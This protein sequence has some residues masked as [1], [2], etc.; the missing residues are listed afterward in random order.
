M[1]T[2]PT[3]RTH[4]RA[5]SLSAV[6]AAPFAALALGLALSGALPARAQTVTETVAMRD[7]TGLATDVYLPAATPPFP[8]L[9]YRTPYDKAGMRDQANAV[10]AA[11]DVAV[12]VQDTRG[13]FASAGVDCIFRCELGDG[14]GD[15]ED[16]L[17]WIDAQSWSNGTVVTDG[18]SA[19][20]IVQYMQAPTNPPGLTA[21]F[22]Q[23][24]TPSMYD[25]A[26]F[27]GGVLRQAMMEG[28]LEA[29]GSA[30]FLDDVRAHPTYDAF[31]ESVQTENRFGDVRVPVVHTGGWYDIFSQGTLDAF[32]GYQHRGG[33]GA[34]GQQKLVM[35]PWTH[36]GLSQAGLQGELLYPDHAAAP[37]GLPSILI[38]WLLYYLGLTPDRTALDAIPTVQYFTMGDVDDPTAPGNEWRSADDWPIPAAPV[39]FHLQPLGGLAESCPGDDGG[40]SAYRYDPADPSPTRGGANLILP[41]GPMDQSSIEARSDV[42]VFETPPLGG[43]VEV[44][45]RVRAHLFVTADVVDT[46]LMVRL[47]DV[48]PDGRSMLVLDGAAR[49]AARNGNDRLDLIAAG[50]TVEIDVDL[51]STSLI[52]AAGHRVRV[53]I[54]SANAPRFLPSSN[55]G[56]NYGGDATPVVAN[57]QIGHSTSRASF[58]ELPDPDRGATDFRTCA[59]PP[60]PTDGGVA[61]DSGTPRDSGTLP[62]SSGGTDSGSDDGSPGSSGCGCRVS[63]LPAPR[64]AGALFGLVLVALVWRR[65]SPR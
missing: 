57:V 37:T 22:V 40:V 29:Q 2:A 65:R 44:T 53:S 52:F 27:Q 10:T 4:H 63:G 62:D 16:T 21:M 46:D 9:V 13:R 15:G 54:T 7:G 47:T 1:P 35:G 42:V 34:R 55:D 11:A 48:Y 30:F 26:F 18:G 39:R 6:L 58:I 12:V 61:T 24:A 14:L 31:W 64:G 43:A 25:H 45:G 19:L 23:V 38:T 60:A 36:S 56:T 50:D 8:V 41:A 3:P 49:V 33:D 17:T 51:W 28:W 32:V 59:A 5:R 20:G